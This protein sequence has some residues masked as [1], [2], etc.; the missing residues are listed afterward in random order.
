MYNSQII[1]QLS[2]ESTISILTCKAGDEIYAMYGHTA[3]RVS[4]P[5]THKDEI[6]NYGLFN[7]SEPNFT[8]KFLRGKLLYHLGITNSQRFI[9]QY[10]QQKRSI[11]EQVLNLTLDQRN[12]IY[13]ALIENMKP[14]NRSYQYDFFFEIYK[15]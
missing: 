3:L 13:R 14:D 4:D 15:F 5:I 2:D 6:Y 1:A 11:I 8:I 10:T 12:A 9:Y 7:F